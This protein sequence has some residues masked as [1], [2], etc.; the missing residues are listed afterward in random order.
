MVVVT[1]HWLSMIKM[2]QKYLPENVDIYFDILSAPSAN[3]L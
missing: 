2:M 3:N 1:H